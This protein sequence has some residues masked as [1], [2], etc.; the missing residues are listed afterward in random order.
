ME[1]DGCGEIRGEPDPASWPGQLSRAVDVLRGHADRVVVVVRGA[2]TL[3]VTGGVDRVVAVRPT[4]LATLEALL[5]AEGARPPA[6]ALEDL[7]YEDRCA[8]VLPLARRHL[9][10]LH[11][12]GRGAREPEETWYADAPTHLTTRQRH[13]LVRHVVTL[14]G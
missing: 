9:A 8:P 4:P 1:L 3:A 7:G 5:D 12:L 2:G 6:W 13:D 10:A 11:D 14:V